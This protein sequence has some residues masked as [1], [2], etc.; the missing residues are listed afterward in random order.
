MPERFHGAFVDCQALSN[1]SIWQHG[2]AKPTVD[3]KNISHE[4]MCRSTGII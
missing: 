2:R 3:W 1:T 4:L